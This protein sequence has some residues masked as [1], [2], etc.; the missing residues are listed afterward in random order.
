MIDVVVEELFF[1]ESVSRLVDEADRVELPSYRM[2][3]MGSRIIR[4]SVRGMVGPIYI[5]D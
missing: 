3:T 2:N 1:Q 5:K 4:F